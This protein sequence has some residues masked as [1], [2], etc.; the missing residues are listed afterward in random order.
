APA[1]PEALV[2][3]LRPPKGPL[4]EPEE[5][6]PACGTDVLIVAAVRKLVLKSEFLLD[7]REIADHR[8][9]RIRPAASTTQR[10]SIVR[11]SILVEGNPELCRALEHVE[12]LA[13]RQPQQRDD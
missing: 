2:V 10:L 3:E 13:K 1:L 9:R 11:A 6:P 8:C 12:Q 7:H 4:R 5:R